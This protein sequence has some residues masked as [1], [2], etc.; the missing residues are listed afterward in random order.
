MKVLDV[1]K[2]KIPDFL[3]EPLNDGD[4][5]ELTPLDEKAYNKA[6][7][8]FNGLCNDKQIYHVGTV[9]KNQKSYFTRDAD[10]VSYGCMAFDILVTVYID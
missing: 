4:L 3:M 7:D 9:K 8:T 6:I 2:F 10:F 5:T 1:Q